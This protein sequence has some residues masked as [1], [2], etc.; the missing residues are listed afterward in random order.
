MRFPDFLIIGA[1][2]S[3]TTTLYRDLL[4]NPGVFMPTEKEPHSLCEDAVL[5]PEGRAA[6]A[7]LFEGVRE[8]QVCGEASTGYTKLPDHP[9]VVGR[10]KALLPG[11]ARFVYLVREPVSRAIS[12]HHHFMTS[13]RICD[14]IDVAVETVPSLID[15]SLYAMQV[16]PWMEAF[17]AEHVR[18][19]IFERFV[20]DRRGAAVEAAGFLG[21]PP[22][23]ELVEADKVFNQSE[24]KPVLAKSGPMRWMQQSWA[25][26]KMVRPVLSLEAR[27]RLRRALLPRANP[28]P[29]PPSPETVDRIIERV[30]PDAERLARLMG[31]PSPIWEFDK[32]RE[33]VLAGGQANNS[34]PESVQSR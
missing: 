25:Y 16:E 29:S 32:V 4:T 17:G 34:P 5:T 28:R 18:V 15:Y 6:Y 23:P 26:R 8:D 9:G 12:H 3:G 1:M 13:G 11:H 22:R 20:K 31:I 30:A 27:E 14:P 2:K 24:S 19:M 10:A 33:K 21:I 7:A